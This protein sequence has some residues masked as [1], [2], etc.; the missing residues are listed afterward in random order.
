MK[1]YL[2]VTGIFCCTFLVLEIGSGMLLTMLYTPD[3]SVAWEQA[4]ALSAETALIRERSISPFFI[5]LT[6]WIITFGAVNLFHKRTA[7]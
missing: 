6:A 1:K 7:V 3:S 2:L 5:A 4:S